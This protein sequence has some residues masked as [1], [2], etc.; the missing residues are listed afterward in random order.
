MPSP[1]QKV[2][3][4]VSINY[5]QNSLPKVVQQNYPVSQTKA[6]PLANVTTKGITYDFVDKIGDAEAAEV[7]VTANKIVQAIS[8][9]DMDDLGDIM[10]AMQVQSDRLNPD[11]YKPNG[12]M[13]KVKGMFVDFKIQM[14]KELQTADAA[15]TEIEAKISSYIN[16][17]TTWVNNLEAM[18]QEN[19]DRYKKLSSVLVLLENLEVASKAEIENFIADES[20]PDLM[21]KLQDLQDKKNIL[22]RILVK[23]DSI[24]RLKAICEGNSPKIRQR[25]EDSRAVIA[26]L[27]DL[28]TSIIPMLKM[29]FALFIQTLD[30]QKSVN[31]ISN[32]R[33]LANKTLTSSADQAYTSSVEAAKALNSSNIETSSLVYV[34]DRWLQGMKEVAEVR[35]NFMVNAEEAANEVKRTQDEFLK[36]LTKN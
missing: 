9:S 36:A 32:T 18:Y 25:Q 4:T 26:T 14:K 8:L 30:T 10:A 31:F 17:Q 20:D 16:N 33:T 1:L 24:L 29:E 27:K 28:M 12:I 22:H 5:L 6:S 3:P 15:F 21:M 7:G 13:A 2:K 11:N 34:R 23:K 19:Y 35:N